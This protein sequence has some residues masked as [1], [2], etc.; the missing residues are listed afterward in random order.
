MNEYV[1]F[2]DAT[3]DLPKDLVEKAEL[4]VIP[5][6]FDLDEK[7]YK[8]RG[9]GCELDTSA[10]YQALR[11]GAVARTSQITPAVFVEYFT[12]ILEAGKDVLYLAFSSGLSGTYDSSRIAIAE[13][14]EEYPDR[15]IISV[16]TLCAASGEGLL[17]YMAGRM[18]LEGKSI[19]E[20]AAYVEEKKMNVCHLIS[21]DDLNHLK[22]GG[23]ISATSATLGMALNI[24]PMLKVDENGKLV[25][26][27]KVRGKKKIEASFLDK[28]EQ[29]FLPEE[30][31]TIFVSHADC[32]EDAKRMQ[33]LIQER[34]PNHQVVITEIGPVIGAHTGQGT[35]LLLFF[36]QNRQ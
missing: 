25:V 20:V 11:K 14:Q 36:G 26:T 35:L 15:K 5:M 31:D 13:L 8:L 7:S 29:K 28:F 10:F 1:I 22:R 21:V 12:P 6:E 30:S 32:F 9:D 23:R 33:Q 3:I 16:D 18:R 19:D 24:K 17:V 4:E 2:T 34:Y 27:D